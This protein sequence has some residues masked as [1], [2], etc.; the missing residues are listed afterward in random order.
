MQVLVKEF[1]EDP[2]PKS[3]FNEAEEALFKKL[4]ITETANKLENIAYDTI[5]KVK[6]FKEAKNIDKYVKLTKEVIAEVIGKDA[7]KAIINY[8]KLDKQ[9]KTSKQNESIRLNENFIDTLENK[10][11]DIFVSFIAKKKNHQPVIKKAILS[12]TKTNRFKFKKVYNN[13][14][15]NYIA[16][17]IK[18]TSLKESNIIKYIFSFIEE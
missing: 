16:S 9:T 6:E 2:E 7:M 13:T 11:L 8:F 14:K 1:Y 3:K 5:E 18:R 12:L 10:I 17:I 15:L 4:K